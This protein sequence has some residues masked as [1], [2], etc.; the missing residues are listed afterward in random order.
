MVLCTLSAVL[1]G[2]LSLLSYFSRLA[3]NNTVMEV[4]F[5]PIACK[6]NWAVM[7]QLLNI[8]ILNLYMERGLNALRNINMTS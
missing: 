3:L 6:C 1:A 8:E 4:L 5:V 2:E 7:T